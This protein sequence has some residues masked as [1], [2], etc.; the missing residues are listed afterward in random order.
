MAEDEQKLHWSVI[1]HRAEIRSGRDQTTAGEKI[2][3]QSKK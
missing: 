3:I 1:H 2:G